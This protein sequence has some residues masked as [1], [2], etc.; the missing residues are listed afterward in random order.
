MTVAYNKLFHF[1][2][3]ST[4]FKNAP[5]GNEARLLQR[6]L[7]AVSG[8]GYHT[9]IVPTLS[10]AK[11]AAESDMAIGGFLLAI[12]GP[13]ETEVQQLIQFIRQDRG[14]DTPIYLLSEFKGVETLS[15]APLGEVTGYIYLDNETP[16]FM[17]KEVI[18]ALER[19]ATE[20]KPP[21]FGALMDYDYEGNQMWTCPGHQ[22]GAFYR[23]SPAGRLFVKH[24]GEAVF[25]NDIDNSVPELGD[26]LIHEGPALR[27]EKAAAK[28]FGAD[29]TYFILNGTS[30]S[31]KVVSAAL[32][33]RG[34][35]V[36]FDRNNHKSIHHGAL[37]LAGAIPI[38]IETDRNP[39]GLIGP[40]DYAALDENNLREQI[41]WHPLVTDRDAWKRARP[42]RLAVMEQCSYDGTIY[43]AGMLL[44]RIGHLCDYVHFDE[45]WAGFMKFHPLFENHFAMGLKNLDKDSPG[46]IATQ[47]THK[48]LAGFSQASQI[49]VLDNHIKGQARRTEHRRFNEM[50]M[51]HCST[52]PFYPLFASL[53]VDA[54]MHKGRNGLALWNDTIRLGIET[55]KKLRALAAEFASR[56]SDER[57][58]WFFDPFVPDVVTLNSLEGDGDTD[59]IAWEKVPTEVLLRDQ[60]CWAFAPGAR[61]HGFRHGASGWAMT[62]PNKLTLITPGLDRK[63]GEYGPI[64]IP[65]TVLAAYLREHNIVPEKCDL[66]SI[67]FL[68]T[69]AIEPGKCASLISR[70]VAFKHLYDSNAPLEAVLPATV[71]RYPER[72]AGYTLQQLCNEMHQ[73]YRQHDIKELQRRCF[74]AEHFP[75]QAMT[76]QHAT[77]AFVGNN[78]DYLPLAQCKGRIAAVLALIYPPGIGIVVPG[79]RYDDRAQPMLDYFL[80]FEAAFNRFPG[81]AYEVQGVYPDEIDGRI[82]FHTY[83]V[84]A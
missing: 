55:R 38:Y 80:A 67:L 68:L 31:N 73:F 71:A 36:L 60:S 61:W 7:D 39:Q 49:H 27:A 14:L 81:F 21:F 20:L 10:G 56:S 63:T 16:G 6:L 29:R 64:G 40:M 50:F 69:P 24:L 34:D 11:V 74:R 57:T 77:E 52:S 70:L 83:V 15:L 3:Y 54:H 2:A 9:E 82:Q 22:G 35:L 12:D 53:D 8:Y 44:A 58:A 41:R 26:L 76:V 72:Y 37:L 45:A 33:K 79:E 32:L 23:R 42:F 4:V 65:A 51:L 1:L 59:S 19:Y 13:D 18:F 75:E 62:D 48:Q 5:E 47:S 78:V 30:T 46:I 66:N 25:R 17:A 43:N 28:V 84:K